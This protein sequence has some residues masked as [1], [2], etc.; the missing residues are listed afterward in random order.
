MVLYCILQLQ[1]VAEDTNR[2]LLQDSLHLRTEVEA[3]YILSRGCALLQDNSYCKQSTR[4][5]NPNHHLLKNKY[6][7]YVTAFGHIDLKT[8]CI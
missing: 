1:T 5:T 4:P 7:K 8:L 6:T 3:D 2:H